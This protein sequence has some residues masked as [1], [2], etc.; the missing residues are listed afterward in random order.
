MNEGVTRSKDKPNNLLFSFRITNN[1]SF[2]LFFSFC[3]VFFLFFV[4]PQPPLK[5]KPLKT[6]PR[7]T[8]E[9]MPNFLEKAG[10][11]PTSVRQALNHPRWLCR[12]SGLTV[13]N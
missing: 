4:V 5:K 12:D 9:V 2:D 8:L 10:I 7:A 6:K 3:F 11:L 13:F 1:R